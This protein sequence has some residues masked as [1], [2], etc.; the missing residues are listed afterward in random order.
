MKCHCFGLVLAA[1]Q[2]QNLM[3]HPA[4]LLQILQRFS[5][6]LKNSVVLFSLVCLEEFNPSNAELNSI[7]HLLAL[8]GTH[9]IL[10]VSGA[11]VKHPE[12]LANIGV[13]LSQSKIVVP[14][15]VLRSSY[16]HQTEL[17]THRCHAARWVLYPCVPGIAAQ[18]VLFCHSATKWP[19]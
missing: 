7:C 5:T 3:F 2:W 17:A 6:A 11:R 14:T 18:H 9:H 13:G 10:H 16:D 12:T 8:L 4:L 19:V 15:C 1:Q